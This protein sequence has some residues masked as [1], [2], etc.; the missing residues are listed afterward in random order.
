MKLRPRVGGDVFDL[1]LAGKTAVVDVVETDMEGRVF[2]GVL[3]DDDPGR[4][5]GERGHRFFF[6]PAEVFPLR[7]LV[8]GIGNVF[9]GD[10][11]FGCELARRVS[12]E[13]VDVA[14]F[15]IRGM[16]LAYA[17]ADY[18]VV[19][20]LDAT[21]RGSAPGTLYLIEP[22]LD[23]VPLDVDAHAM[24]PVSV[25]ALAKT[26][27]GELPRTLVLGCEPAAVEEF[28]GLSDPVQAALDGA[29]KLLEEVLRKE[30]G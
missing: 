30:L 25:L 11:G 12:F 16:D 8:A 2:V 18:D 28:T 22:D 6:T 13:G 24:H 5:L 14:D 27:G 21:P 17:L 4:D 7:V 23:G 26:L 3:V 9:L 1:A 10:D 15:G 29:E 20:F 19:V